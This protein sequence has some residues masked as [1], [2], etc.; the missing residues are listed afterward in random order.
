[1][2]TLRRKCGPR[3]EKF[4][5]LDLAISGMSSMG[6]SDKSYSIHIQGEDFDQLLAYSQSVKKLMADVDGAVEC[7][8]EL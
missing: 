8:H 4:R 6:N 7:G 5:G 1:M 2:M 3:S